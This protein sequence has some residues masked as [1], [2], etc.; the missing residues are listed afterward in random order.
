MN[1]R[2][3]IGVLGLMLAAFL[4]LQPVAFAQSQF[5]TL[6]GVVLDPSGAAV[7][8]A[9]VT[10]KNSASTETRETVTNDD[11]FFGVPT[12]PAGS[13]DVSVE[14]QGFQVWRGKNITLNGSDSRSIKI[15]LKVG[16]VTDSVV[17][18]SST[19]DLAVV[20]SGEKSALISQ[21]E[22]QDLSLEGRNA[23]EF[24]KL[25]PGALLAPNA[26]GVNKSNYT[27]GVVG[28]NGFA[29]GGNNGGGLSGV[30][31]NGQ[32]VNITQDGQNTFDPGAQ[33]N[34]TPVNPNPEMISEVKVLTSNFSA[35]NAQGPVVVNTVTKGGGSQFHGA[36]YLYSRNAALNAEDHYYKELGSGKPN[37]YYYY[38]GFNI[39]GPVI[40]PKTGFNKS[41]QKLFF[42][43]GYENYHQTLDGGV[44][45]AFV[46][47]QQMIK[48]GDFSAFA[49]TPVPNAPYATASVP[50]TPFIY[51]GPTP[52]YVPPPGKSVPDYPGPCPSIPI[53]QPIPGQAIGQSCW[54]GFNVRMNAGCTI[55]ATG[56]M[57]SACIS[58]AAQILMG[59]FIPAPNVDP[60][61]HDGFNYVQA[62]S[63]PMNSYQNMVRV[64][65]DVSQNTKIYGSWSRQRET[66]NF[67]TGQWQ[68]PGTPAVPSPSVI[69]GNNGSDFTT[70]SL[71]HVF[72]PTLTSESRFGYTYINFPNAPADPAKLLKSAAGY[73]LNGIYGNPEMPAV[74]DW[75]GTIPNFGSVGYDY[76]PTMICYKGIPSASENLTKVIGT[77]TTKY[78]F[79]YE[80]VYNTQDNWGQ[81]MGVMGYS[82]WNSPTG[83]TYADMLMGIG[84][85]YYEQALP[86]PT[87]IAQNILSFYAT[88]DWKLTRRLTLQYGMRFEH[89]AKPYA[90][91]GVGL[92][93]FY[94]NEYV[95]SSSPDANT[96]VA[97]HSIDP[98]V[99]LSGTKSRLLFY[100]PRLGASYDVFGNAR[101]VIR[102]G[103]GM[104]RAYD[105]LQSGNYT[106]PAQTALGSVGWS[107][108]Q[109]DPACTTWETIDSYK[110]T[111]PVF[112]GKSGLGPGLKSI[113]V[114]DPGDSEQPLV[115]AYSV[116]IDQQL[117]GRFQ[118]EISYVGNQSKDQQ[119]ALNTNSIPY[120]ALFNA[121][122]SCSIET[123][124]CQQLYRPYQNYQTITSSVTAGYGRF[125]SLQASVKRSY[126]FLTLQGNYTFSKGLSTANGD[127]NGSL[128]DYGQK[129]SYGVSPLNR[130][131]VL[132]LAYVFYLPN[133]KGGNAFVR[134]AANGWQISG[135]TQVESGLQIITTG[136]ATNNFSYT[137]SA[138]NIDAAHLYGVG[139][140]GA[141][142]DLNIFP[143]LT[144]NPTSHLQHNQ[145]LNPN[146]FA[147]PGVGQLGD[148]GMPY[149]PGPMFWNTDLSFMKNFK[150][151]ERQNLQFRFAF[152]NP[153]NH[154]LTSF[155]N[156]DPNLKLNFN[157]TGQVTTQNCPSFAVCPAGSTF[158]TAFYK[159]GGRV[160]ELGVKYSF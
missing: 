53:T 90:D 121:P 79:Y 50:T 110:Q 102:G 95:A 131:Q 10:V 94:S 128:P 14:K 51:E 111:P 86:P 40:V 93:T 84:E 124:A 126:G 64:D 65:F 58:P 57:S 16:A 88:D 68:G 140:T 96:G 55:S 74:L 12:L 43:D 18:E 156:G 49:T 123:T 54:P 41:R 9:K 158:G 71:L 160:I 15:D 154:G 149:M 105:S 107:C 35:E 109:M 31:I 130:A 19:V 104:Y 132:S 112:D 37:D 115:Y 27:G 103:W 138:S 99:P 7:S 153:L 127:L 25:L 52:G 75:Q 125:D 118:A 47:T 98:S 2:R 69:L 59:A 92:A 61:T 155:E 3:L 133:V 141:A 143:V 77:H 78:G 22:L 87:S 91:N 30:N 62:F 17:V 36:A 119:A 129:W 24:L 48:T 116:N 152:F 135:V 97:W 108:G 146:C 8:G 63:A 80:H 11:G 139:T 73:P 83:N 82:P 134:G 147:L 145:Y 44:D 21:Q 151:K 29:V 100:S 6:S 70:V 106:S 150:I 76:H 20:D 120:G 67:P 114:M 5:A 117:P 32:Q 26:L 72:S 157:A 122:A 28:I 23:T 113:S 38:P 46:P 101:T 56:V 148:A 4:L 66:A 33:G 144:C 45:R 42:F 1:A 81:F 142:S 34:A 137:T 39:G 60:S 159:S 85:S 136:E 13:Y 89:Y